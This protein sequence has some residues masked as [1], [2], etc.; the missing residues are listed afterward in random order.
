MTARADKDEAEIRELGYSFTSIIYCQYIYAHKVQFSEGSYALNM[1]FDKGT[2]RLFMQS[3]EGKLSFMSRKTDLLPAHLFAQFRKF[4]AHP[5]TPPL[6]VARTTAREF[7]IVNV[8]RLHH[9]VISR[10]WASSK[11]PNR[12][13]MMSIICQMKSP[14]P[15]RICKTPEMIFPV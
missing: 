12:M 11:V 10:P 13:R 6:R 7:H 9:S 15:V 8:S 1:Q 14:P 2:L 5:V 3:D 4:S